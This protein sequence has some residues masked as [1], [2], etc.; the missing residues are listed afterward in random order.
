MKELE[1]VK[2]YNRH[3]S[4][5]FSALG[6]FRADWPGPR[7][8]D[9]QASFVVI[10]KGKVMALRFKGLYCNRWSKE[11]CMEYAEII[12]GSLGLENTR[13]RVHY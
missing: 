1:Y 5:R 4:I 10:P 3:L 7:A 8:T 12:K 13:K 2:P 6:C 11:R 9:V